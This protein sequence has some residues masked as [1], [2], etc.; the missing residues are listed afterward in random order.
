MRDEAEDEK[1]LFHV[2]E[3]IHAQV[4]R[5]VHCPIHSHAFSLEVILV[6]QGKLWVKRANRVQEKAEGEMVFISPS[7]IHCLWSDASSIVLQ[8]H[9]N[10][11]ELSKRYPIMKSMLFGNES[12]V[13]DEYPASAVV[14]TRTMTF[15]RYLLRAF[16]EGRP[17]EAEADSGENLHKL[18][19]LLIAEYNILYFLTSERRFI[20]KE[21]LS[22]VQRT[23][24]HIENSCGDRLT[25]KDLAEREGISGVYFTQMWKDIVSIPLHQFINM[26]RVRASE[27]E[28]LSGRHRLLDISLRNGFSD[29][30]YFCKDF[31]HWFG[32]RPLEWRERWKEYATLPTRRE[33]L[34]EGE[35][36]ALVS[37]YQERSLAKIDDDTRMYRQYR[38]LEE[39]GES[40]EERVD[41]VV[42]MFSS[43]NLP[44]REDGSV[45]ALPEWNSI[46][47]LLERIMMSG[48][49][50]CFKIRVGDLRSAR[51]REGM[52]A[53]VK[54]AINHEGVRTVG[55][56]EFLLACRN[57]EE[58]QEA[59]LYAEAL[60]PLLHGGRV[61]I[62]L[63]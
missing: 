49:Q 33:V 31:R 28:L 40:V 5:L 22:R 54:K 26:V 19:S 7:E 32:V 13:G 15:Q 59:L 57:A 30:R 53:F 24:R 45:A 8:V 63:E 14:R 21:S 29:E 25:L 61:R 6:V 18:V 11:R 60:R 55:G 46:E 48:H 43:E 38:I 16:F 20:S 37:D 58:V 44:D 34:T 9:L 62:S 52:L 56:W 51:L 39:L 42:D 3:R 41:I 36:R 4:M 12:L 35:A 1:L 17:E 27:A 23:I 50:C 10:L 2:N 47:L